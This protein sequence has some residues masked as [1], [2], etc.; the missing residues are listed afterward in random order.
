MYNM[1]IDA[2]DPDM[3]RTTPSSRRTAGAFAVLLVLVLWSACAQRQAFNL[4]GEWTGIDGDK[5][6]EFSFSKELEINWVVFI[7]GDTT[8]Q[9]PC[10]VAGKDK[11]KLNFIS[12]SFPGGTGTLVETVEGEA[13]VSGCELTLTLAGGGTARFRRK[14][15]DGDSRDRGTRESRR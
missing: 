5:R 3:Q 11:I 1:M 8:L 2:R 14:R 15:A 9:G 12:T 7:D 10:K 13:A 6:L 4:I